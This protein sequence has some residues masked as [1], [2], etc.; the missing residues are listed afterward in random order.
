MIIDNP[1]RKE[2]I[3]DI[4]DYIKDKNNYMFSLPVLILTNRE[5]YFEDCKYLKKPVE[6]VFLD[7]DIK[8]VI[9]HRID[10]AIKSANSTSFDSFSGMLKVLPSLVYLKDKQ[11]RYAFCSQQWHHL[12]DQSKSIRGLTDFDIRKDKENARIARES[13]L[14]VINSGK[15]KSYIIKE[16]DEEGTEYLQ[17]IKEPLKNEKGDVDGIIAIINNVTTEEL[18]RQQLRE[19]SITDQLTGLYNRFY[20]EELSHF[21]N[22]ELEYPIA[23]ISAD[24]DDLKKINDEFGHAAG[25]QYIRYACEVLV[26]SL[27]KGSDIF[28][29][30]GDE[31]LAIVP[32]TNKAQAD[33]Y[34]LDINKNIEKYKND[35]FALKLS[36]GCHTII[37]KG[38]SI[39]NAVILSDKEMYKVKKEHKKN[40]Q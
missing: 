6:D 27:P 34:L 22:H 5:N 1:S 2:G 17:V 4:L 36:V 14:A 21:Q 18:L 15:G 32:K 23:I 9:L 40:K 11:G 38:E 31:F 20:F 24:C 3:K 8:K 28:R 37:K 7:V 19:K 29:M 33:K 30:G 12:I 25:D 35:K 39:E 26:E 10:N 13:D 16:V